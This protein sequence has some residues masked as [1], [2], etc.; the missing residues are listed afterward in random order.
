MG[1]TTCE[2]ILGKLFIS[3]FF[4]NHR[5]EIINEYLLK[6][7]DLFNP[8][9]A[10]CPSIVVSLPPKHLVLGN[11]CQRCVASQDQKKHRRTFGSS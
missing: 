2:R 11:S 8:Q 4:S 5:R 9:S 10:E 6:H 3:F 1:F 7:V